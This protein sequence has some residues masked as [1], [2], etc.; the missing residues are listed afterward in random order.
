MQVLEAVAA[1]IGGFGLEAFQ[2]RFGVDPIEKQ[3][4]LLDQAR[5]VLRCID[6]TGIHPALCLSVLAREALDASVR[7]TEGA[8]H[9]DFRL[10]QYLAEG[11]GTKLKPDAKILDP[12]CGAGILL[13]AVSIVACRS[14]RA[15][16]SDWLRH[17][18]YAADLSPIAL[19]G[20]LL[21][22]SALT[23]DID[24][25][26]AMRQKWRIQDSLLA[27]DEV[28]HSMAHDG[29]DAFIA[30]PPWE[31][32]KLTRHEF[33]K[34][35]GSER[36]YGSSYS[37]EGLAGYD[38]ARARKANL[39]ANLVIK[40]PSLIGGEPDFYVAFADMALKLTRFGG[41][42]A[43]IVPG[44]LIRS[45]N[46]QSLRRKL[47]EN[48]KEL[49]FTIMS[50]KARH[51]AIDT[52][53]KFLLVNYTKAD[54]GVKKVHR[55]GMMHAHTSDDRIMA[56]S[57]TNI[58]L[59][60]LR[61]L[62]PDLTLP[63]VRTASEWRLFERMQCRSITDLADPLPCKAAFCREVDMTRD[64]PHFVREPQ[65]DYLPLVEGR[66]VHLHRLGCKAYAFGEGRSARWRSCPPG[67]SVIR[68]Q[69]WVWKD[70]LSPQ[71]AE[72]VRRTRVGFCDITGQTN[73]RSMMAAIIPPGLV[74]GNKVPT[75]EFPNDRSEERLLLWLAV[76][77]SLPF[78]WLI[79]RVVTTTVNYFV[80]SS[81]RLPSL[82]MGSSPAR[83]LVEIARR[84][85][86]L[87][88]KGDVSLAD[89]WHTASLR[90]EADVIVA[91]AY[92]CNEDDL[93]MIIDDFPLLDREQPSLPESSKS[94]VTADMLI[95]TWR[96]QKK[97][98]GGDSFRRLR[99]AEKL[100]A[101]PYLSSEFSRGSL[102]TFSKIG[103]CPG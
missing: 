72:R 18:I 100:G 52:R 75:V 57:K 27:E 101:V 92:G 71:A 24:S 45:K 2:S 88:S 90:A 58:P 46:T 13:T 19:R 7:R 3:G 91:S 1:R 60:A 30:N 23:D 40:Y 76:V 59:R 12:A 64:R 65:P 74:C 33:I 69:F 8:Y 15:K 49:S 9:T 53:F 102:G 43:L 16:T 81:V 83:R 70:A 62:R 5:V 38:I 78:D 48:S 39:A 6:H 79:R 54:A 21:S 20:T 4:E 29:F 67:R 41:I 61:E 93:W 66:M 96:H 28:W 22:L 55:I 11:I 17:S 34:A 37:D 42:G 51:F 99:E 94:T 14:D 26:E 89:C 50:N 25:L 98:P 31:K 36:H 86:D 82:D 95:S 44:G 103:R 77:N 63:E 73:E 84:L 68:P 56:S 35:N 87:D 97:C 47:I 32:V 85:K 10:A 80:L